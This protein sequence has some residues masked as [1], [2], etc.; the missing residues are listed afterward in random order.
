MRLKSAIGRPYLFISCA[1]YIWLK[2][3]SLS[4]IKGTI[5]FIQIEILKYLISFVIRYRGVPT[6]GS[7]TI[8]RFSTNA[9]EMKKLA[10]RDYEDLLQ[11]LNIRSEYQNTATIHHLLFLSALYRYLK[12][13]CQRL[14]IKLFLISYFSWALGMLVQSWEFIPT[15]PLHFSNRRHAIWVFAWELSR[16][17]SV[18]NTRHMNYPLR[19]HRVFGDEQM[20]LNEEKK[21]SKMFP[22]VQESN[23]LISI[24]LRYIWWVTTVVIFSALE[25]ST[26]TQ[27]CMYV[28]V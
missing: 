13:F 17:R 12:T 16:K 4:L 10:A 19:Q 20:R 21:L 8:R 15:L 24:H 25:Q 23:H 11:V 6:F 18:M 2:M 26:T 9:S 7:Q 5:I 27:L 22:R 1:S 28:W 14:T 3:L